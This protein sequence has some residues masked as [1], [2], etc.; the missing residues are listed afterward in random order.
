MSCRL[1]G[2]WSLV[3]IRIFKLIEYSAQWLELAKNRFSNEEIHA[4]YDFC[5][6]LRITL[7]RDAALTMKISWP[8]WDTSILKIKILKLSIRESSTERTER[9]IDAQVFLRSYVLYDSALHIRPP[10]STSLSLVT[11]ESG[12]PSKLVSI[13]NNRNWNGN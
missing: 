5:L 2:L 11:S 3:L 12:F 6:C 13:R 10:P 7:L 1:W 9:Y 4:L 8:Q